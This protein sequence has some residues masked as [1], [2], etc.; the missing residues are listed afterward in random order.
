MR[1]VALWIPYAIN[2]IVAT[3]KATFDDSAIK[4]SNAGSMQKGGEG[5]DA[6]TSFITLRGIFVRVVVFRRSGGDY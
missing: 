5:I 2:T 6:A 1:S 4:L 3:G